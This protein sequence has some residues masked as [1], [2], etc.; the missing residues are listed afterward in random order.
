M[1]PKNKKKRKRQTQD[2]RLI[3]FLLIIA[4]LIIYLAISN[5]KLYQEKNRVK[6]ESDL[7]MQELNDLENQKNKYSKLLNQS[8]EQSFL[9]EVA[10]TD[11]YLQKPEEKV[12]VIKKEGNEEQSNTS[13]AEPSNFFENVINWFKSLFN[14]K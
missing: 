14:K 8:N 4:V 10:R 3:F 1:I 2:N 11:L 5:F 7:L 13:Q 12:I 6:F 9:E